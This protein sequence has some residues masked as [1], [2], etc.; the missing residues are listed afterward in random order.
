M[1]FQKS[2]LVIGIIAMLLV[3]FLP[4]WIGKRE[5]SRETVS[6]ASICEHTSSFSGKRVR[7]RGYM[8][9]VM[10]RG[11]PVTVSPAW[12]EQL[13]LPFLGSQEVVIS[14]ADKRKGKVFAMR[15][16]PP[17]YIQVGTGHQAAVKVMPIS[18][19]NAVV[20]EGKFV[21]MYYDDARGWTD[22]F[23]YLVIVVV[24]TEDGSMTRYAGYLDEVEIV[25]E[26]HP[27]TLSRNTYFVLVH[28]N[29]IHPA[30]PNVRPR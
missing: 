21:E 27:S 12:I 7:L 20:E 30:N 22:D 3:V 16:R 19:F 13:D 29:D 23:A 10:E 17:E 15:P 5:I 1:K 25:G 28:E 2:Y 6:L 8:N 9:E 4:V 18:A 26:V 14:P 11:D 24:I